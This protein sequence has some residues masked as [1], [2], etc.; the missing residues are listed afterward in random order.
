MPYGDS[1]IRLTPSPHPSLASHVCLHVQPVCYRPPEGQSLQGLC[2]HNTFI[3]ICYQKMLERSP[4]QM[5]SMQL[6]VMLTVVVL[7]FCVVMQML[8]VP[9]TL[10]DP[11]AM[12][13]T[14]STTLLLEGFS[15]P[16]SIQ[17]VF[18]SVLL[19]LQESLQQS[20]HIPLLTHSLFHPPVFVP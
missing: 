14:L 17:A 3:Y 5:G 13:D 9:A 6:F 19:R 10:W 16:A 18:H 8:G 12:P 15:I 20:P 4:I 1:T 7:C 11:S 2:S